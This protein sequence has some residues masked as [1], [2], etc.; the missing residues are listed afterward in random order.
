LGADISMLARVEQRG[1]VYVDNGK[2]DDAITIFTHHGWNCFRLR[3]FVNPNGQGGVVNSLEYTRTLARRIKAS[4]ATFVLDIH[5]SDTWADPQHQVTPAAWKDQDVETLEKTVQDYTSSVIADLRQNN[6]L[7]D[8]VQIG[9]EITPGMLWP[10]GQLKVPKSKVKVFGGDVRDVQPDFP[11][12]ETKQWSQLTRLLKAGIRGVRSAVQPTDGVRILI[13]I[14]CGGDWPVT[15]WYFDHLQQAGVEYDLIGQSYYPNWHGTLDNV[16]ENLRESA[17]R[18]GKPILIVETAY[19]WRDAD[20]W[21][22]RPNMAWPATPDGQRQFLSDLIKVVRETPGGLGAGVLYWQP[23][24][25]SR[26]SASS[27]PAFISA[28]SLFDADGKPLPAM[29]VLQTPP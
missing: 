16:R 23:E 13:H 4:G 21:S 9:N 7:P 5:Y 6:A 10:L 25:V 1:G 19:P 24:M 17:K 14:D 28:T 26:R 22:K 3:L 27:Q 15:Q 12:D 8:I 11:Y 18:Y 29:D 2:P 20:R